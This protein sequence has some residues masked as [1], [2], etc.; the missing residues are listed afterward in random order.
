MKPGVLL[1]LRLKICI[2]GRKEQEITQ[3]TIAFYNSENLF[4][5][6]DDKRTNDDDFLPT[7]T[8]KWTKKRYERKVYKLGSV[9]SKIGFDITEKPPT[10]VGLAEVENDLVLRDLI[11]SQDLKDYKYG[12]VHYDSKDERGIDVALLYN[13]EVFKVES[14]D[15]YS[16]YI[17]TPEGTRDL[18]RDILLV[19]G[20]LDGDPIHVIVNHW[21]SRHNGDEATE[22]KRIIAAK[23]VL[24]IVAKLRSVHGSPK[25]IIMGDFNDNPDSESIKLLTADHNLFNTAETLWT[26]GRGTESHDFQWNLFDQIFISVNLINLKERGF[27]FDHAYIFDEKFVTKF[28]G[29]FK[30]QPFRTYAGKKYIGGFSDHFPIYI[31]LKI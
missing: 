21:P 27:H 2:L 12:Y 18:T 10:L 20:I 26:R 16:L 11:H 8:K 31:I 6:F 9:I 13:K 25:I 22:Y 23:K 30:G 19:S 7:S 28:H 3:H 15:T 14:S 4:D 1:F 29:R 24:E 5:I 17:E